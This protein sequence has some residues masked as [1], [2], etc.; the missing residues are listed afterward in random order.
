MNTQMKHYENKLAYEM[1]PADLSQAMANGEKII[2][3]DTR[4]TDDFLKE[5]IPQAIN[6]PYQ[7]MNEES[8]RNLDKEALYVTYCDGIGCKASTHG[9]LIL[10]SLGFKVKEL[11]G[12]IACWKFDGYNTD[13]STRV[14]LEI[15]ARCLC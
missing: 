9:A 8:T 3:V 2:P 14:R 13:R 12:G 4:K 11:I 6:L 15:T 10:A 5:H 7:A 1:G